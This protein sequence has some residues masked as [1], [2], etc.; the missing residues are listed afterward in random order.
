M[1]AQST[2]KDYRAGVGFDELA[3]PKT[4]EDGRPDTYRN[5]IWVGPKWPDVMKEIDP[6]PDAEKVPVDFQL[7]PGLS[8]KIHVTDDAGNPLTGAALSGDKPAEGTELIAANF[9]PTETRTL[10]VR[11][12]EKKLGRVI[13]VAPQQAPDGT[14]TV[15]LQPLATVFGR[16]LNDDGSPLSGM[17]ITPHVLPSADFGLRLATVPTDAE[18][19]F[20]T[21]LIPGCS[22]SLTGEGGRRQFIT[23]AK[24]LSIQPGE[25]KD[26]GTLKLDKDGKLLAW[27]N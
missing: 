19:R 9:G 17:A 23:L 25:T 2:L 6:P 12:P 18:G 27:Q 13:A 15:A 8:L 21:T 20:T 24:E 7:D 11:H 22:Y 3:V 4:R 5:P 14:M 10:I 26:L 1:G 16:V